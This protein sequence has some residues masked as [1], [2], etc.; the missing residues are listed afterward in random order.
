MRIFKKNE[1]SVLKLLFKGVSRILIQPVISAILRIIDLSRLRS[2]VQNSR[3]FSESFSGNSQKSHNKSLFCQFRPIRV[4][5]HLLEN[6][7]RVNFYTDK[8]VH[9]D[10][11]GR[12]P[13]GSF[14]DTWVGISKRFMWICKFGILRQSSSRWEQ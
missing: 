7:Y 6:V 12:S 10:L 11:D 8:T 4:R 2:K 5:M 9:G 13:V 3:Y 1:N 14:G